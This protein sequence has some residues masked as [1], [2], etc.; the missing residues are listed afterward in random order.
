VPTRECSAASKPQESGSGSQRGDLSL[1]RDFAEGASSALDTVL[2]RICGTSER[3]LTGL[4]ATRATAALTGRPRR[5][6]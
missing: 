4:G 6:R 3:T 2:G 5:T 1:P